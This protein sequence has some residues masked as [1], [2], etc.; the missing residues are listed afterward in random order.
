MGRKHMVKK[1]KSYKVLIICVVTA[2]ITALVTWY[3]TRR[4][5]IDLYESDYETTMACKDNASPDINGCCPGEE[6]K[7]M[8]DQG[9]NCC[10][11]DGGDCFP[12]IVK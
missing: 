1:K 5:Y 6:L 12:P 3:A 2:V 9:F 7:D 11:L 4:Y 10:P 8:G